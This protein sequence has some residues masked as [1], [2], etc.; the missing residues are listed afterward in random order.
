MAVIKARI[1][2]HGRQLASYL[3]TQG[4]NPAIYFPKHPYYKNDFLIRDGKP[5]YD[6]NPYI[7]DSK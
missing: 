5:V 3:L 6:P 7:K 1:R 4:E 2:G